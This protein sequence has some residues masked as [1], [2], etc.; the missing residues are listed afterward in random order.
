MEGMFIIY[1]TP[2]LFHKTA[3]E[4]T[5]YILNRYTTDI[6]QLRCIWFDDPQRFE[7]STKMVK[8]K[9]RDKSKVSDDNH[10]HEFQD[11]LLPSSK[12]NNMLKCRECKHNLTT[13]LALHMLKL[14][15]QYLTH[16]KQFTVVGS[17][18][19]SICDKALFNEHGCEILK[20]MTVSHATVKKGTCKYGSTANTV[21]MGVRKF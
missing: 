12:W 6:G 1:T 16:G 15:P 7:L 13:N 9:Q 8:R 17:L 18:R 11:S 5:N 4:Y 2:P 20:L 21:C 19:G 14:V 3:E 10:T